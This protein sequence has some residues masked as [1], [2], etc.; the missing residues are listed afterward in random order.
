MAQLTNGHGNGTNGITAHVRG[1]HLI[2]SVPLPD[3]ESVFRSLT[4]LLPN[5]LRRITDGETGKRQ[6]FT[7]FQAE[8]F[9]AY[10]PMLTEFTHNAPIQD[11]PFTPEQVEDGIA[12]LKK[13]G[14][15]TGYDDAAIESY[16]TFRKLRDEGVIPKGV[17][18]QVCM[19]TVANVISPFTQRAFQ[20]QVEPVYEEAF[21]KALRRIQ[22]SIPH[23]DLAIQVDVALDTA[24]WEATNPR[25]RRENSGLEW[26]QPW[27]KGD[28]KQY[29]TDYLVRWAAQIDAD[30]D[31][32]MHNCYGDMEHKHWHEPTSLA[33]VVERAQMFMKSTK[34]KINFFHCPVPKSAE[35]FIDAYLAPLKELVPLFEQHGTEVYLGL[36]HEH[37]PELTRKYIQA[38]AKVLPDGFG[39]AAE[40]G[41][42]RMK[43][44]DF[45]DMLKISK[46]VSEPVLAERGLWKL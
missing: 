34:H 28:V 41:G 30:V 13:A 14:I 10:P 16:A 40:C 4:A 18:F 20:A 32:G 6:G 35:S 9:A 21:F 22:D 45:E 11:K 31:F 12:I 23:E 8:V 25:T 15:R 36:V 5:R 3:T 19:P 29:Q 1:C 38:A 44:E 33:V 39:I 17:K 26:F 24:F 2:G 46:E 27:W 7:T 37:Q 42:G 43:W